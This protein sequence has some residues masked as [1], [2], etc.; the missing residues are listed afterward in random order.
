ML[1]E[2]VLEF[3]AVGLSLNASKCKW[4][5]DK[6]HHAVDP[7][8]GTN[9]LKIANEIIPQVET[10]TI[11]G[12]VVTADCSEKAPVVHRIAQS[13]KCYHRWSNVLEANCCLKDS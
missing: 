4:M 12:S 6:H 3:E 5:G 11:L 8:A 9:N 2:L 1:N 7:Y 13:W 10:V